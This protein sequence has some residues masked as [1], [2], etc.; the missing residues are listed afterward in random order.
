MLSRNTDSSFILQLYYSFYVTVIW[1]SAQHTFLYKL[2]IHEEVIK[3]WPHTWTQQNVNI[4]NI[5][6]LLHMGQ[7]IHTTIFVHLLIYILIL[8]INSTGKDSR[9]DQ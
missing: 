1:C 2:K 7:Y 8:H 4:Q 5:L 6:Q 3:K 9:S